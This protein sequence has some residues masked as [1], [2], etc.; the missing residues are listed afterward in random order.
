M[1]PILTLNKEKP[2]QV[3]QPSLPC[4]YIIYI[5]SIISPSKHASKG[6]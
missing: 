2:E 5:W 6:K 1:N 4:G 3:L